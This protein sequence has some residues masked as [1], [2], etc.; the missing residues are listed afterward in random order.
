M[1]RLAPLSRHEGRETRCIH[2]FSHGGTEEQR[3][4][5]DID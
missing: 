3:K 5:G 1:M 4:K 2:I